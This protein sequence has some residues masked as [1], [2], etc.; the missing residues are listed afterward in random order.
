MTTRGSKIYVRTLSEEEFDRWNTLVE[1]SPHGTV[2]HNTIW[3][4]T[5]DKLFPGNYEIWGCYQSRDGELIGGC[6]LRVH[7]TGIFKK[8][9][10]F[11]WRT[12]T[13]YNGVVIKTLPE[14]T[15][16]RRV[17]AFYRR[18]IH[19]LTEA[20]EKEKICYAK[21]YNSPG[22]VDVRPFVSAGWRSEVVYTYY[23]LL[24]KLNP[25]EAFSRDIRRCISRAS[26]AGMKLE[27]SKNAEEYFDL[28]KQML[29]RQHSRSL[30]QVETLRRFL[31]T[32]I[33]RIYKERL[34]EMW[35]LKTNSGEAVSGEIILF[36][37][38]RAYSWSAANNPVFFDS[39]APSYLKLKLIEEYLG[40]FVEI[41]L[42]GAN[43]PSIAHFK[44]GF[45]PK[46]V[47]H[48]AVEKSSSTYRGLSD[49]Y[50][51]LYWRFYK[52]L[53]KRMNVLL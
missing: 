9:S 39:G 52:P 14:Q 21:L 51:V 2:F 18:V 15:K 35:L 45:G 3:L 49:I 31:N 28:Y 30:S 29:L 12:M 10:G 43:T 13:F 19:S 27:K 22:L 42:I 26:E 7:K 34:G 33:P 50:H 8:A 46:L 37:S 4:S 17:E 41:D 38:K 25:E 47:P 36:D 1:D 40:R 44:A 16:T 23:L 53:I 5:C 6:P 24:N 11:L 32:I 48:Y 20:F